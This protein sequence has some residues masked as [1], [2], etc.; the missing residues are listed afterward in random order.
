M[1][2]DPNLPRGVQALLF[3]AAE[4]R[5]S[6]EESV[7]SVLRCAGFREVILPVLDYAAPYAG[8]TAEGDDHL[9]RFM[10]RDGELLSLR[11]DFTPM[12]A[13]VLAPRLSSLPLPVSL[14]YRGDVVRDEKAG[15]GRPREF[16]QIGAECYGDSSFDADQRMLELLLRSLA[17]VPVATLRV[18]L[19]YANLL[20]A[21]LS[22]A[23]PELTRGD[24]TSLLQ[25]LAHARER[26]VSR[27]E[28]ALREAGAVAAEA[29]EISFGL[30]VGFDPASTLFRRPVLA[31][32]ASELLRAVAC[33]RAARPGISVTVDLAGTPSAPYYSG[34]TFGV[35]ATG[36]P[37]SL[38]GGGRYDHLL[39]R[40]GTPAPATGFSIGLEALVLA[41]PR[42]RDVIDAPRPIRIAV[43]KGRLLAA[44]LAALRAGGADFAEPDGRRLLV[45]DG[46]G[47]F[48]LLLLKDDDV[49]TYVAHG[50]ADLGVVGSDRVAESGE[51]V[52]SPVEFP[53]GACR[54]A[55][56][57]RVG[58]PFQPDGHPV[59]I[60]TKYQRLAARVFDERRIAHE[61]V[62][63]AGS[64]ELAAALKLTDVIVD[65]IETGS[66]IAAH[67]LI[68]IETL[69]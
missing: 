23:A 22:A 58:E 59:R 1:R 17:D 11:A 35:D 54:L 50:G 12:A 64:V 40:F 49:P 61:I 9:Y 27:V 56:I 28:S 47:A 25:V 36:V 4:R 33:A 48:E 6:A 41:L 20:Q 68:E 44:T 38:A 32:G 21:V 14:F 34:L 7:G 63:L 37:A 2:P 60:G 65:L 67:G 45:N 43:G 66:T 19:G 52:Y 57:G 24:G 18:T 15:V 31:G 3:D 10:D 13:R 5:R 16:A 30:L 69:L 62:P 46:S 8:V 39:A 53:F 29:E 26:R 42:E 55:L 51:E